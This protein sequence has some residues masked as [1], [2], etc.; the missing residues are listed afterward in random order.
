MQNDLVNIAVIPAQPGYKLIM[1]DDWS[2]DGSDLIPECYLD[3]IIGWQVSTYRRA[4]GTIYG[5]TE[6]VTME[7]VD[8]HSRC[9]L[10]PDGVV[11]E[12]HCQWFENQ[13]A[14]A[15]H[16]RDKANGRNA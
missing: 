6:P 15:K 14:F 2:E 4:D 3:I 1:G 13:A 5:Y 7:G 12:P 8:G 11:E 9:I 16:L 10:R